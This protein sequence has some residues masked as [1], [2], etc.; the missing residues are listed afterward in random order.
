MWPFAKFSTFATRPAFANGVAFVLAALSL[1]AM[2]RGTPAAAEG[3][4]TVY[5]SI[6][7]EQCREGAA[8]FEKATGIKV[9]MIRR[10]TGETYAQVKAETANPKADVWW[11]G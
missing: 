3:Q 10:S 9:L 5:C 8:L 4:V 1:G 6:L 11:G 7:E 2:F